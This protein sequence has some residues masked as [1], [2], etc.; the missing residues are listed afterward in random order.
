M[1]RKRGKKKEAYWTREKKEMWAAILAIF[2]FSGNV[3]FAVTI[4]NKHFHWFWWFLVAFIFLV[5]AFLTVVSNRIISI[6]LSK[7]NG[8]S[9]T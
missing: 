4:V 2:M 3:I 5:I 1:I 9:I 6:D 7:K 8:K